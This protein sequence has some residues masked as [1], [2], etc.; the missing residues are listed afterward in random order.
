MMYLLV[1]ALT[2]KSLWNAWAKLFLITEFESTRFVVIV[3][4]TIHEQEFFFCLKK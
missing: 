2:Q 3:V 4:L 1:Y